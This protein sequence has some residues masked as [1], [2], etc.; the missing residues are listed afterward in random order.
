MA[1]SPPVRTTPDRIRQFSGIGGPVTQVLILKGKDDGRDYSQSI[2]NEVQ[3][4]FLGEKGSLLLRRGSAKVNTTGELKDITGIFQVTIAGVQQY[5]VIV[6]GAV[7]LSPYDGLLKYKKVKIPELPSLPVDWPDWPKPEDPIDE[8]PVVDPSEPPGEQACSLAY[9]W[10]SS[11]DILSFVMPYGGPVPAPQ[12]W[13]WGLEGYSAGL[14]FNG[15]FNADPSWLSTSFGGYWQ[16]DTGPCYGHNIQQLIVSVTGKDSS[17]N[18]IAAG[19]YTFIKAVT[20]NDGTTKYVTIGLQVVASI[21]TLTP[22]SKTFTVITGDT[23]NQT[24]SIN[25]ANTG[26]VGSV[27]NWTAA[28]TGDVALTAIAALS[29]STGTVNQGASQDITLTLTNPGALAVGTYS[30]TITFTAPDAATKTVT[31]QL[32]VVPNYEGTMNF[33]VQNRYPNGT[34]DTLGGPYGP[35]AFESDALKDKFWNRAGGGWY[36][37]LYRVRATGV[38]MCGFGEAGNESGTGVTTPTFDS[39]GRP[40]GYVE[41]D[42][43]S[44]GHLVYDKARVWY[45][46]NLT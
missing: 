35:I 23:G 33:K 32:I 25:V 15:A 6:G 34:W 28:I 36:V 17:G 7:S 29:A 1:F 39:E 12:M 24:Q 42:L 46:Y 14:L 27:L 10:V 43:V 9:Q 40:S 26:D 38:W 2:A 21:I 19:S 41:F 30:A 4:L 13:Y 20:Y 3:D 37:Q 5:G 22:L 8:V 45:A 16:W 44:E 18:W 31:V 11:P